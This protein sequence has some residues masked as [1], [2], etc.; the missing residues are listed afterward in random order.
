MTGKLLKAK[1]GLFWSSYLKE[2]ALQIHNDRL[3]S[4]V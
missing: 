4:P 1:A 3:P 2:I